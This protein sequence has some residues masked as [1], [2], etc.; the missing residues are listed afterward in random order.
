[1]NE[2]VLELTTKIQK[3][4]LVYAI[5]D[6]YW[7]MGHKTIK[8]GRESNDDI[9]YENYDPVEGIGNT[10]N[11]SEIRVHTYKKK[12]N[13]YVYFDSVIVTFVNEGFKTKLIWDVDKGFREW[14][15]IYLILCFF[16]TSHFS[17]NVCPPDS[18]W[19]RYCFV[20]SFPVFFFVLVWPMYYFMF[21]YQIKK[22]NSHPSTLKYRSDFEDF[23][24]RKEKELLSER[25]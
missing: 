18:S 3:E 9:D 5:C 7:T 23:I 12:K 8:L 14:E 13:K 4:K 17:W 6:F 22:L 25:Y 10:G 21:K 24:H 1:M 19:H 16:A 20:L 11:I 2:A 15:L